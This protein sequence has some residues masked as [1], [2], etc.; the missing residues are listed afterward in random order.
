[1][2]R[3]LII[4]NSPHVAATIVGADETGVA[5]D[6]TDRE[7]ALHHVGLAPD[8]TLRFHSCDEYPDADGRSPRQSLWTQR[9]RRF[10]RFHAYREAGHDTLEG[11]HDVDPISNPDRVAAA[12]VAVGALP[13][14]SVEEQFGDLVLQVASHRG[15]HEPVVELPEE[16]ADADDLLVEQ[17]VYLEDDLADPRPFGEL[18]ESGT[19]LSALQAFVG[20]LGRDDGDGE[21]GVGGADDA[22][23]DDSSG[24]GRDDDVGEPGDDG[25]GGEDDADGA[26]DASDEDDVDGEDD[27]DDADGSIDEDDVDGEDS[28]DEDSHDETHVEDASSDGPSDAN[29]EDRDAEARRGREG[30]ESGVERGEDGRHVGDVGDHEDGEDAVESGV[31][32]GVERGEGAEGD[33][34]DADAVDGEWSYADGGDDGE[35]EAEA[36]DSA[37]DG[38]ADDEQDADD[39]ARDGHDPDETVDDGEQDADEPAQDRED[40]D[41]TA[42]DRED[43][44][45]TAADGEAEEVEE[46]DA[47]GEEEGEVATDGGEAMPERGEVDSLAWLSAVATARDEPGPDVVERDDVPAPA[48]E[49][50]SPV[51]VRYSDDDGTHVETASDDSVPDREPDATIQLDPSACEFGS[52]EEVQRGLLEHLRCRIRDCY[53]AAGAIPPEDVRVTGPGAP[54]HARRYREHD[55]LQPYHDPTASIDWEHLEATATVR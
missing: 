37:A 34:A 6:V 55:L 17:D 33:D 45:Q 41:E 13:P 26:E 12:A 53:V 29:D 24:D 14:E 50:T 20:D 4:V 32:R 49:A 43:V 21:R 48:V 51:R 46:A 10:A 35:V 3:S 36:T 18:V 16:A 28:H 38:P 31:E 27:P 22:S 2:N 19:C 7:S 54:Q 52:I 15:D 39:P 8:G 11:D 44:A 42:D 5:V 47:E 40:V 23:D 1:M 9:A 30:D 25:A